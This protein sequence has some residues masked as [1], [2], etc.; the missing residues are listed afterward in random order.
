M[1]STL[2]L[3]ELSAICSDLQIH[4]ERSYTYKNEPQEVAADS[5]PNA[6]AK[7][8][9]NLR[10][11]VP[12]INSLRELLYGKCYVREYANDIDNQSLEGATE[13]R[14]GHSLISDFTQANQTRDTWDEGWK[15]YQINP[16]GRV[17]VQKGDRS[18]A[19]NPGE[20]T[21]H[22]YS[23]SAPKNGDIVSL[24]VYPGSSQMQTSF[25]FA[26]GGTL[27]DQFDEFSLIRFYFNVKAEAAPTLL[28]TLSG[29]LNRYAIP[30]RF[31]SLVETQMYRRADAA[32]LYVAKRYYNVVA[33]I[34]GDLTDSFIDQLRPE[35]PMFCKTLLPGIGV[36]DDPGTGESFGMHRC[37]LVA[38]GIVDAWASG[39][40]TVEAR[41]SAIR[42]RFA[43]DG[44]KV[45]T[46][47]LN[48][49]SKDVFAKTVFVGKNAQ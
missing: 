31:K 35:T 16:D 36:G 40:Q 43:D 46:P 19:A 21:K 10:D 29:Q 22:V 38:E 6:D 41:L 4:S 7:T 9:Q 24:R 18:R 44:F 15:I 37:R 39:S 27:T 45:E 26:F 49:R 33:S 2:I 17:S 48:P 32:V 20:F 11:N 25:F 23:G 30:Y 13:A 28:T 42:K 1:P 34:L 5:V 47:Y 14:L 3:Q 8:S 12:L